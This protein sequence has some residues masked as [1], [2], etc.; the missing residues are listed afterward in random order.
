VDLDDVLPNPDFAMTQERMI[1]APIDAV[2]SALDRLP[3]SALPLGRFLVAVRYAPA[4]LSSRRDAHRSDPTFL[5][6]TPIPVVASD[7]PHSI[8][9]AGLSQAWKPTGGTRPPSLTAREL[10]AWTAPGWIKVAMEFRLVP[11]QR[12]TRVRCETRI[13]ATDPKTRRHF[14]LYWLAIRPFASAIRREVLAVVASQSEHEAKPG[15]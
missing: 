8:M 2:W 10:R 14:A 15:Q 1:N 9:S 4:R 7:R 12:G 13:L 11:E 3:M 5:D 6:Q